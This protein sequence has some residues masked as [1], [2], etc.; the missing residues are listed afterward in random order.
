MII[1][2]KDGVTHINV[3]SKAD[4]ELGIWLSNFSYSPITIPE[5]GNFNSIEGY[6]YWLLCGDDRLRLT[7]GFDAKSL[8]RF[9]LGDS[10]R[11]IDDKF[12]EKIKLAID[13]KIKSNHMMM[14][15]LYQSSL[16]LCHYYVYSGKR[17]DAGY[18]WIIEHIDDRR[19]LL[20]KHF[21]IHEK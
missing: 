10:E 17:K 4:T 13:I 16:P 9:I 3:Y 5:D 6:W 7:T 15:E 21:N 20:R 11:I 1:K 8:G 19:S 2:G 12:K 14:K 18:E